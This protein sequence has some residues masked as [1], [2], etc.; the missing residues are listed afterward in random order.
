MCVC[1]CVCVR[2]C[3]WLHYSC[4]PT[5]NKSY[6]ASKYFLIY[7]PLLAE[8]TCS[9]SRLKHV[10]IS[11]ASV[12]L[13]IATAEVDLQYIH[14]ERNLEGAHAD[15]STA[16]SPLVIRNSVFE[17]N[18]Q[19]GLYLHTTC[20]A[21]IDGCRF[22]DNIIGVSGKYA[23][24]DQV[25][26]EVVD[27]VFLS[28]SYRGCLIESV[29]RMIINNTAFTGG[30]LYLH[31]HNTET[32]QIAIDGCSFSSPTNAG[33]YTSLSNSVVHM[34]ISNTLVHHCTYGAT[35]QF[36]EHSSIE[37]F[38][39]TIERNRWRGLYIRTMHSHVYLHDSKFMDN[40]NQAVVFNLFDAETSEG[41]FKLSNNVFTGN[42]GTV[43]VA[44]TTYTDFVIENNT[45]LYNGAKSTVRYHS[46]NRGNLLFRGNVLE[47]PEAD[48]DLKVE[49]TNCIDCVVDA[50][51]NW[52]GTA[53]TTA[54]PR[55][56]LDFFLDMDLIEVLL[57]PALANWSIE[58]AVEVT[59]RDF[60]MDEHTI[61]GRIK[62]NTTIEIGGNTRQV[63]YTIH[64]PAGKRLVIH[65]NSP[66]SF[67]GYT[68][69]YVEG[70]HRCL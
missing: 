60:N 45:F 43:V 53:D 52:W 55:R 57:S 20:N 40:Y 32:L 19:I 58:S 69:I 34:T 22:S 50:R 12:G 4:L 48:Y 65:L 39:V 64:V 9:G 68:G 46:P 27:S 54:I 38:N 61:G 24:E 56:I 13:K 25:S 28:N 36:G 30:N 33:V 23:A 16:D 35:L 47:N 11:G 62:E 18:A 66:L 2:V 41:Y 31:G 29:G 67:V 7:I 14:L 26:I 8:R 63:Q 5:L 15:I 70:K 6:I 1:V 10:R 3:V 51:Y 37:L 21:S 42:A 44:I 49:P 59:S 17:H